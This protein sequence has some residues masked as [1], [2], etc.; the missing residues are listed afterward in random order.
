MDVFCAIHDCALGISPVTS[1]SGVRT[2]SHKDGW[3]CVQQKKQFG[4]AGG[5][6]ARPSAAGGPPAPPMDAQS[7]AQAVRTAQEAAAR[8]MGSSQSVSHASSAPAAAPYHPAGGGPAHPHSAQPPWSQPH[9]Q[10]GPVGLPPGAGAQAPCPAA[11]APRITPEEARRIAQEA[12][13]R[14]S[15]SAA[16]SKGEK[17]EWAKT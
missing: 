15:L 12:A 5:F 8:L 9:S 16:Q 1:Y 3:F 10:P 2:C 7:M 11:A 14:A 6:Q 17:W 13:Q 4:H